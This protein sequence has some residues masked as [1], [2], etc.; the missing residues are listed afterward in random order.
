VA[1][2]FH[3]FVF[4][5]NVG[6]KVRAQDMDWVVA[7]SNN[8]LASRQ[9]VHQAAKA[10]AINET[11]CQELQGAALTSDEDEDDED[12]NSV[13]EGEEG[14]SDNSSEGEDSVEKQGSAPLPSGAIADA[15][16]PTSAR[17]DREEQQGSASMPTAQGADDS[18]KIIVGT[19]TEPPGVPTPSPSLNPAREAGIV[20]RNAEPGEAS[21]VHSRNKT[22]EVA[23]VTLV[24]STTVAKEKEDVA[25][26]HTFT[27]PNPP[28]PP[29]TV[30]QEHVRTWLGCCGSFRRFAAFSVPAGCR[31]K[32]LRS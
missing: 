27:L 12:S 30:V 5:D 24:P 2:G 17:T 7:V 29:G 8:I 10:A 14:E 26:S 20:K 23:S 15:S 32:G 21:I 19:A 6:R 18:E 22:E 31:T 16:L 13:A 25:V 1:A 3:V 4:K 9:R 11:L 28:P